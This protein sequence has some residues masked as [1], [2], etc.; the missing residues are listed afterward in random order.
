MMQKRSQVKKLVITDPLNFIFRIP[1]HGGV[2]FISFFRDS[3]GKTGL[4]SSSGI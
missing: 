1:E 4:L 3:F 2:Y